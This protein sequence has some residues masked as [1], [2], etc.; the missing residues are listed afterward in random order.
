MYEALNTNKLAILCDAVIDR[1]DRNSHH[2]QCAADYV[3]V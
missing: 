3:N 1:T 2:N